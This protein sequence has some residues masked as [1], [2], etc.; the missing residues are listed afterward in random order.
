MS[1]VAHPSEPGDATVIGAGIVGICCASYLQRAGFRVTVVDE[2]PPGEGCSFGNAGII[3]PSSCVP[4]STPGMLWQVPGY[5]ADPLG[6][7]A[8][9]LAYFPTVLPWL[10]RFL[11]AGR[12][13][14]VG[15]ISK[16]MA[17]L[18]APCLDAYAPLVK[19]AGAQD[20]I[21][22]QGSLYVSKKH[23]KGKIGD[24][25][26]HALRA[27]A[28]IAS[29][30]VGA[31]ELRQLDPHL[32]PAFKGGL[33]FPNTAQSVNSFRLVQVLAEHLERNGGSILRRRVTGFDLGMDGP[34]ALRTEAGDL[35]V[36][37][38]VIAA[39]A[40]S[41]R[42]AAQ[43]GSDVPLEAERGYH[44]ML[45][46]PG[47]MPRIPVQNY[48]HGFYATPMENGLRF[49]GTVEFAGV[50]APPDYRRA[51]I[52][53]RLGKEMYPALNTDGATQWMGCRPSLPD[54]LP[55]IDRS[56]RFPKVH[57]AFGHS[58]FGLM[59]AAITGKLVA[60]LVA[61]TPSSIDLAPYRITRF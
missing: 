15:A 5:L 32:S 30:P 50:D 28:G 41:H 47:I 46:D 57:Y 56:P 19:E 52:L 53:L 29:E 59:G 7:L 3:S 51:E 16:A 48:D 1:E 55:V 9:R 14:R 34:R 8:L 38:L 24:A 37:R 60:E 23:G 22:Q 17:A 42:L 13:G 35:A 2:R 12:R 40:W 20:L 10:V 54:S 43:L 36:D 21:R 6:P 4:I 58:H 61:G 18:H 44:V 11:L 33:F 26:S 27:A 31:D 39:G 25:L 45:P 49:A